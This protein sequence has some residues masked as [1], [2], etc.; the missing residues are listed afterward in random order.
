[1]L[2]N[3]PLTTSECSITADCDWC[4]SCRRRRRTAAAHASTMTSCWLAGTHL[5]VTVTSVTDGKAIETEY[6]EAP[7]VVPSH[8]TPRGTDLMIPFNNG[9]VFSSSLC[10]LTMMIFW[11]VKTRVTL[12]FEVWYRKENRGPAIP[13]QHRYSSATYWL[14]HR[15]F[16]PCTR[17]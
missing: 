4:C 12:V 3:S 11:A 8:T 2:V 9:L 1:M 6:T 7:A 15:C 10:Y 5:P 14:A 13:G 16:H 17:K